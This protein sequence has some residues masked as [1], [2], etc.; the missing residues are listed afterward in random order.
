MARKKPQPLRQLT[1]L[2]K[3]RK[4]LPPPSH[5]TEDEKKYRRAIQRQV[6]RQEVERED[7]EE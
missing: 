7:Q 2:K 1:A 5:A 3:V 4:P 6:A